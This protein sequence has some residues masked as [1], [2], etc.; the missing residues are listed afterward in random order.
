[1]E[2]CAQG[3]WAAQDALYGFIRRHRLAVFYLILVAR[4]EDEPQD[5]SQLRHGVY[6]QRHTIETLFA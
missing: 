3:L 6:R 5:L 2:G 1:M 4:V